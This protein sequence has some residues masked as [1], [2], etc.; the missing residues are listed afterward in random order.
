VIA[1]QYEKE[2]EDPSLRNLLNWVAKQEGGFAL[3]AEQNQ[4]SKPLFP[5]HTKN[6]HFQ[7][8]LFETPKPSNRL[9]VTT[10][11]CVWCG[12]EL[13]SEDLLEMHEDGHFDD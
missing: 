9:S 12:E 10:H 11:T 7:Q 3:K 8:Q 13:E 4:Y 2:S 6:P 1:M 5:K